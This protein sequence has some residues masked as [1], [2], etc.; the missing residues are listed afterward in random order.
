MADEQKVYV[1][2]FGVSGR[3]FAGS[4]PQDAARGALASAGV[5]LPPGIDPVPVLEN[6]RANGVGSSF[7]I[8]A[9]DALVA[10][11]DD[12]ERIAERVSAEAAKPFRDRLTA[13]EAAITEAGLEIPV[14]RNVHQPWKKFGEEGADPQLAGQMT[15]H[16]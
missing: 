4:S 15:T 13:I 10:A 16:G 2:H 6:M 9:K 5:T 11:A 7:V 8:P 1:A 12:A 14:P 3:Y